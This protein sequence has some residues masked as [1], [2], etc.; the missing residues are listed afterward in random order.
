M[1]L[2]G[3]VLTSGIEQKTA[4]SE[5]IRLLAIF[6]DNLP[7]HPVTGRK[8]K[9]DTEGDVARCSAQQCPPLEK[10]N[11][12]YIGHN[13][14]CSVAVYLGLSKSLLGSLKIYYY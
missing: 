5:F 10:S 6:G 2:Y 11:S 1:N 3:S 9:K 14:S 8:K 4:R 13:Q 7:S 12:T